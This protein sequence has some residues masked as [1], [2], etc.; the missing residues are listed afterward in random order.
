M[1]SLVSL[2]AREVRK[3]S[4]GGG[5]SEE[6]DVRIW[7]GEVDEIASMRQNLIRRVLKLRHALLE[8][9]DVLLVER[10]RRPFALTFEEER[11]RIRTI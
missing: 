8:E 9:R 5:A 1:T 10:F 3:F 4:A 6:F 11:E 2:W 7:I